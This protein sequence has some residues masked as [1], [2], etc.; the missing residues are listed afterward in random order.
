MLLDRL[1]IRGKLALLVVVPLL[2]MVAMAVPVAMDRFAA[3]GRASD[4]A[5]LVRIASRV[6]SLVQELQQER[7]MSIGYLLNVTPRTDLAQK[8]ATVTDLTAEL[9]ADF[10]DT[11]TG[12]LASALEGAGRLAELR[13][14]VLARRASMD[15]VMDTFAPINLALIDALQLPFAVDTR[16]T[17]GRQV[18]A[19]DQL[20][21]TDE[22]LSISA[23]LGPQIVATRSQRSTAAYVNVLGSLTVSS[24]AFLAL[25]TPE[26]VAVA[27]SET[28]AVTA[29]TNSDLLTIAESDPLKALQ[30]IPLEALFPIASSLISLGQFV[31][32]KVAVDVIAEVTR[33]QRQATVAAYGV[34][35]VA[36]VTLLVV[37]ML[38]LLVARTV[39]RPL[40]RLTRS[41]DRVARLAEEELVRVADDETDSPTPV[42]LDPVDIRG[43]DEIGDLAR[44]FDRVQGTAARLVERQ[45]ASRRNV[46]EMFGHVGRR[47]QNLVGRQLSLIDRLEQRETDP[48]RLQD[49]Y[50]LDHVSSRLR[51]SASSLV[52]LS[53][54]PGTDSHTK[55]L[56]LTDVVR[57]ALGEIE[58]YT[59]VDVLVRPD[60]MVAPAAVGDLV[61]TLAELMENATAFSP[62][63]TRVTVTAERLHRGARITLVDHGIGLTDERLAE[64]NAR[65]TQRERLDLAPTEVLGLFVVGRLARRHDWR[66]ELSQTP[67]GGLTARLELGK[68]SLLPSLPDPAYDTDGAGL[69]T[70]TLIRGGAEQAGALPVRTPRVERAG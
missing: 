25:A 56:P 10:G 62:P 43:R 19:L 64:E 67:G 57:L 47:T 14:A 26:Q 65:L 37:V 27:V 53:G 1:R 11:M 3:A 32:K 45:V 13:T 4:T 50:R 2:S 23:T 38:S 61:L 41:A 52:V 49:L 18:L 6:G 7:L 16:T 5:D 31:E 17:A 28:E 42:R 15:Q 24:K 20:L 58:A 8:S 35:G 70:V 54:S 46:A 22:G 44:A 69:K 36:L 66:V 40:T 30:D 12:R 51:R 29:R 55:P 60:L 39:A 48:A 33:Q 59:R 34:A 63:H 9:R 68:R 21:R